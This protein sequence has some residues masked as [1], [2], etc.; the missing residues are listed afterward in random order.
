MQLKMLLTRIGPNAKLIITG[1]LTQIDLPK[2]QRSGLF[3]A[4]DLL[5]NIQ[6]ISIVRL[7]ESDVVRHRLVK[8]IIKAYDSDPAKQ[9][10]TL[11]NDKKESNESN[12]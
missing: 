5:N 11:K 9:T 12:E 1:D 10:D 7:N 2:Y 3:K 6:G 4:L 8:M